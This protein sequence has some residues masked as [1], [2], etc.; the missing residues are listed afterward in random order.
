MYRHTIWINSTWNDFPLFSTKR[1]DFPVE[2]QSKIQ[3]LDKFQNTTQ[4]IQRLR[5]TWTSLEPSIHSLYR[6]NINTHGVYPSFK[7]WFEIHSIKYINGISLAL[8]PKWT[9]TFYKRKNGMPF[10]FYIIWPSLYC[11]NIPKFDIVRWCYDYF[12]YLVFFIQKKKAT[13]EVYKLLQL[14]LFWKRPK[15]GLI[16]FDHMGGLLYIVFRLSEK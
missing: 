10:R 12:C 4:N 15:S 8:K 6:I 5:W 1:L 11:A 3:L 14:N 9:R 7:N 16:R 13:K 2:R